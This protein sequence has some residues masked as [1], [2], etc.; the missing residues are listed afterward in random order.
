VWGG[1]WGVDDV[2]LEEWV[3]LV[4]EEGEGRLTNFCLVGVSVVRAE[5]IG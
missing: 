3:L 4:L 2:W 5:D 1:W